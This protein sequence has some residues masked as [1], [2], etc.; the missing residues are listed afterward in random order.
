[1]RRGRDPDGRPDCVDPGAVEVQAEQEVAQGGDQAGGPVTQVVEEHLGEDH[2]D[3][4]DCGVRPDRHLL[5]PHQ[6]A[7]QEERQD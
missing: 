5:D 7:L 2:P 1:M 6:L 4:A 3:D